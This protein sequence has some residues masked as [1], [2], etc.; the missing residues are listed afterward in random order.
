[1]KGDRQD[2]MDA[3][4]PGGRH[5]PGQH[6][7]GFRQVRRLPCRRGADAKALY[8]RFRGLGPMGRGQYRATTRILKGPRPPGQT[9]A[10]QHRY[11]RS[12]CGRRPRG[13]SAA[14]QSDTSSNSSSRTY[15]SAKSENVT[16][17]RFEQ[18]RPQTNVAAALS[19]PLPSLFSPRA[20]L[21]PADDYRCTPQC[22]PDG[23][24]G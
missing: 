6:R 1:V 7:P 12:S 3:R 17:V 11:V 22:C 5:D 9:P 14:E 18:A 10:Q 2:E 20:D 24:A 4:C 13:A 15:A 19:S 23:P 21:W 16:S 8:G